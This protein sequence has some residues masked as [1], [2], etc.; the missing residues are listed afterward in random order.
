[1]QS[2]QAIGFDLFNTLIT[3]DAQALDDAL[4]R[5]TASLVADGL[6]IDPDRFREE[7]REAAVEHVLQAREDGLET[8]NRLWISQALHRLGSPLP[9]EDPRIAKAIEAYFSAFL[10]SS[11]I[12]PGTLET[13]DQLKGRYRLGLL[14]NFTHAPAARAIMA[15]VGLSGCFEVLLI[16]GELGYRKPHPKTFS[17]LTASLRTAPE[18]TLYIGDDPKADVDGAM[19]SGLLPVWTT[20]VRDRNIPQAP[21]LASIL[22]EESNCDCPRISNWPEL[23]SLLTP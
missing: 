15:R 2:I 9:P 14:S 16:S 13:L 21:G 5:L 10:E 17:A 8:H 19:A 1:M 22:Q 23:F 20:Y 6:D 12:I 18:A 4:T 7:H 3:V 11:E